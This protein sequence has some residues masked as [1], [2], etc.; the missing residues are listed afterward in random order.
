MMRWKWIFMGIVL[1]LLSDHASPAD[2]R[3]NDDVHKIMVQ[4][5]VLMHDGNSLIVRDSNGKEVAL[6][7]TA[8]TL[9]PGLEGARFRA[10]DQVEAQVTK[11]REAVAVR[12]KPKK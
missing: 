7:I 9:M 8:G 12:P 3:P 5:E 6:R 4:G 11:D 10:G 2:R 1:S